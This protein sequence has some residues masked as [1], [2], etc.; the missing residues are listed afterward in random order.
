MLWKF[1]IELSPWQ[2]GHY[3]RMVRSV[4]RCFRKVLGSASI[5]FDELSTVICE[6][7]CILN[8]TPL[9]YISDE[10]NGEI[11]T[12]S[13]LLMGR[14]LLPLP[15]GIEGKLKRCETDNQQ[16]LS[17]RFLHLTRILS[18]FWN[19]WK[20]EYLIKLRETHKMNS[21]K[22]VNIN[23]GDVVSIHEDS[24]KKRNGKLLF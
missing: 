3:E 16:A 7:E 14:R 2:G 8:S 9:S 20:R 12:L 15:A 5:S 23:P 13:H 6:V 10:A 4:K 17:K 19:R 22:S 18:H 1:N 24:A 21:Q 11:L